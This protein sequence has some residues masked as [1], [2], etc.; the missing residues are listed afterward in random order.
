M[1]VRKNYYLYAENAEKQNE[2][3]KLLGSVRLTRI[4]EQWTMEIQWKDE[5][6]AA[7]L[8]S[9]AEEEELQLQ[10]KEKEIIL[11]CKKEDLRED[12]VQRKPVG[13]QNEAGSLA[14]IH[15]EEKKISVNTGKHQEQELSENTEKYI[16]EDAED[17][18]DTN[19]DKT[20]EQELA[21][22]ATENIRK[23]DKQEEDK[24][25][26]DKQE[27]A[28][29][30]RKLQ[31]RTGGEDRG[32]QIDQEWEQIRSSCHKVEACRDLGEVYRVNKGNFAVLPESMKHI[33]QNSFLVHGLMNY[34]YLLLFRVDEKARQFGVGVPGVYY[35]KEKL[36]A[37]MFGF[38]QFWCD[39]RSD[40]GKFGYYLRIVS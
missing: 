39:G 35:E 20:E 15:N 40:N 33:L 19:A 25:E 38:P 7:A 30:E 10:I 32:H 24:Q 9:K 1:F 14:G 28:E 11:R 6:D 23:E 8:V 5:N 2:K 18:A 21:V 34:G 3:K 13:E 26:E 12:Q 37:E 29:Q 22:T 4:E 17:A 16:E 31:I 36:V 27:R